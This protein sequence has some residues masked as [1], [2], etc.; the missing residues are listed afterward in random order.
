MIFFISPLFFYPDLIFTPFFFGLKVGGGG[1]RRA[2][3]HYF[4][5]RSRSDL[6]YHFYLT[7][8]E[9]DAYPFHFCLVWSFYSNLHNLKVINYGIYVYF[10]QV[11]MSLSQLPWMLFKIDEIIP[12]YSFNFI[13]FI[14]CVKKEEVEARRK[15][16][17]SLVRLPRDPKSENI[18]RGNR[19]LFFFVINY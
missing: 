15:R 13:I 8:T 2:A 12:P 5:T 1:E 7:E 10:V 18:F 17:R 4:A 14:N 9:S 11:G 16:S 3:Q 19:K 6:V